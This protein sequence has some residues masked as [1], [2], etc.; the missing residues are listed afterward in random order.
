MLKKSKQ[1][2]LKK[3]LKMGRI[4]KNKEAYLG[5][6]KKKWKHK[7]VS[8]TFQNKIKH[9]RTKNRSEDCSLYLEIC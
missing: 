6:T 9:R 4:N 8:K 1:N 7:M 3:I 5:K 2:I